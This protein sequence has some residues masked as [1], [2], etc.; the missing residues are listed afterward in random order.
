MV[1]NKL[2]ILS[3]CITFVATSSTEFG[4]F[5]YVIGFL[6]PSTND[7]VSYTNMLL[8]PSSNGC[9]STNLGL[10]LVPILLVVWT[11]QKEVMFPVSSSAIQ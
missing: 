5:I 8:S 7:P 9:P 10:Q 6:D 4:I 2:D 1:W 3:T 11:L